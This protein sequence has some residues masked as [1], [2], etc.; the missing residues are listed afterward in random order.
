MT[1]KLW[2]LGSIAFLLVLSIYVSSSIQRA[3]AL[4]AATFTD[5]PTFTSLNSNKWSRAYTNVAG[6]STYFIDAGSSAVKAI[7][8]NSTGSVTQ[9][10]S[11]ALAGAPLTVTSTT[12]SSTKNDI[13]MLQ[14]LGGTTQNL[15]N[16]GT[17][18][19]AES[20]ATASA[21][22]VGTSVNELH[23]WIKKTGAPASSTATF[24]VFD[25][26]CNTVYSFGTVDVSTLTGSFVETT[27]RG[28]TTGRT[29]ANGDS[30]GAYYTGG[31]A[32]NSLDVEYVAADRYD[33]TTNTITHTATG[34]QGSCTPTAQT[35]R[36][37]HM[38]LGFNYVAALANDNDGGA[39]YWENAGYTVRGTQTDSETTAFLR[40][41]TQ[42]ATIA[43]VMAEKKT[44]TSALAN[45]EV[46]TMD[47][48][49]LKVGS[50]TGT[51]TV[52][53]F[54]NDGSTSN[55]VN[56]NLGTLANCDFATTTVTA[57]AEHI[58]GGSALIGQTVNKM[59]VGLKKVN[60]PTGNMYACIMNAAATCTYT[61][62]TVDIS[63]LTTSNIAYTFANLASSHVIAS[64][65]YIGMKGD[66]QSGA[67]TASVV[68]STANVY[69]GT[70]SAVAVFTSG[71][72][73]AD[74]TQDLGSTT[75]NTNWKLD[76]VTMPTIVN[77]FGTMAAAS[78]TTSFVKYSFTT[79]GA[80]FTLS[81]GATTYIGVQ[82]LGGDES[83]KVGVGYTVADAF[84]GGANS[85]QSSFVDAW[86]DGAGADLRFRV[87]DTAN[88][89]ADQESGAFIKW[90]AGSNVNTAGVRV[91]WKD[92]TK[93][94]AS[95]KLSTSTDDAAYTDRVTITPTQAS[96]YEFLELDQLYSARY[97][98]MT[99][100]TWGA[101]D[102]S[103]AVG[104]YQRLPS[105][106][107]SVISPVESSGGVNTV[108]YAGQRTAGGTDRSI[109]KINIDTGNLVSITDYTSTGTQ[110]YD[111]MTATKNKIYM[112]H[113]TIGSGS[114]RID[115]TDRD[116][117]NL[118]T[119]SGGDLGISQQNTA[120]CA[121]V[122][123]GA[124]AAQD[125]TYW[126][127]EH[128]TPA[129][130][131]IYKLVG[132][133]TLTQPSTISGQPTEL[134]AENVQDKVILRDTTGGVESTYTVTKAT[135][136]LSAALY[137]TN[138]ITL[139]AQQFDFDG[140]TRTWKTSSKVFDASSTYSISYSS[141]GTLLDPDTC[142]V[143]TAS[144]G[145]I[146][147]LDD[148]IYY[149]LSNTLV[150]SG[151]GTT[152]TPRT[153]T[154]GV[155]LAPV[156]YT[157]HLNVNLVQNYTVMAA[158]VIK[159]DC[160]YTWTLQ[161][162]RSHYVG[163]DADCVNWRIV[164]T[165]TDT[166]G[167][168]IPYT[169]TADLV[170]ANPQTSY[171][172]TLSVGGDPSIYF[173]RSIYDGKDVDTGAFDSG[174]S[175]GQRLLYGQ[176]YTMQVEETSS[177]NVL[178]TGVIC[179][180]DITTKPISLSGI[181]I[182]DNWLK[183]TWSYSI[184]RNKTNEANNGLLFAM[185]KSS[186]PYNASLYVTNNL[187]ESEQ[188]Y[189]NWFNFTGV[190]GI[191]VA[192]VTGRASDE[193][194]YFNLYENDELVLNAISYADPNLGNEMDIFSEANFGL[195]FGLPVAMIFPVLTAA[196]FPKNMSYF[197]SIVTVAVI[198]LLAVFRI[199]ELP[200]W[201]WALTMPMLAVAVFVGYKRK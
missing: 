194:I 35:G 95:I 116:F 160:D 193:T 73:G 26:S 197:G 108:F 97:I 145:T 189:T 146:T 3:Q 10:V 18:F 156:P 121:I 74:A 69:D 43:G 122:T 56:Q 98:K 136:A 67:N 185:Q 117:T 183:D 86:S 128:S 94:P 62:G 169:R 114:I 11:T 137:S 168:L 149:R 123:D 134:L 13:V 155:T 196:I 25:S 5:K 53:E 170:H 181:T 36:E 176:C 37:L 113:A 150:V 109:G 72:W 58:N 29:L 101:S 180:N 100:V 68:R 152:W 192:N 9:T 75:A 88:T 70:A 93:I 119:V 148:S 96:G 140:T 165:S 8:L 139:N 105:T 49:L 89:A 177:G 84:D 34:A 27:F 92:A 190:T 106:V 1:K 91:F 166:V 151:S 127:T 14:T 81:S 167:R 175:L 187:L 30:I 46:D 131:T 142:Y 107:G 179:A 16:A 55:K 102:F 20:L 135:D 199:I 6:T 163:S 159:A 201:Y 47:V 52:A 171:T 186:E 99:V 200:A 4:T 57:C 60:S 59:V 188:S 87:I 164:P 32:G 111:C 15:N 158:Q 112:D 33:G 64:G 40:A 144:A 39:S 133:G 38:Q 12:G 126:F 45:K 85:I 182:P 132:T 2:V 103:M 104:E 129:Q 78:L 23:I 22:L 71:V 65:E 31:S 41:N 141:T 125:V 76:F 63:T 110:A 19:F 66:V 172:I 147:C 178:Q 50:P 143:E 173:L 195:L 138:W 54:A 51:V 191:A 80:D 48:L 118:A 90:D 82:F 162:A 115:S 17:T 161:R 83:N 124:A 42:A 61:F 174:G 120:A 157:E 198:G 21:E 130:A 24:A 184:T 44:T 79:S 28:A 77:T 7:L 153:I 154:S